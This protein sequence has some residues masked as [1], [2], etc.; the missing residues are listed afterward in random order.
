MEDFALRTLAE[1]CREILD[2]PANDIRLD[3]ETTGEHYLLHGGLHATVFYQL[4]RAFERGPHR[5]RL[6]ELFLRSMEKVIEK[7][8]TGLN[9]IQV[10]LGAATGALPLLYTLQYFNKLSHTRAIFAERKIINEYEQVKRYL[11]IKFGRKPLTE[12]VAAELTMNPKDV[13][14]FEQYGEFWVLGRGFSLNPDECV[15]V[16]D[17]VGTTFTTIRGVI[18][19]AH[20]ACRKNSWDALIY[21]FGVL[22]DRSSNSI[23]PKIFAPTLKFAR[24]LWI[25][26]ESYPADKCVPCKTGVPLKAV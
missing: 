5:Q 22:V 13:L 1:E 14:E 20:H 3:T 15:F 21:G 24:G 23:P 11:Y 25:P 18:N 12:E 8:K 7:S 17:D 2:D 9:E 19:A 10:L 16:V 6:G 4:A 26:L